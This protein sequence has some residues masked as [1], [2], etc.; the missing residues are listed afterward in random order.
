MAEPFEKLF[1]EI[2]FSFKFSAKN[3][4]RKAE[5]LKFYFYE[6]FIYKTM[7]TVTEKSIRIPI[8]VYFFP[9]A[10]FFYQIKKGVKKHNGPLEA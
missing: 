8:Y 5:N 7:R 6:Q 4:Q 10:F 3:L 1:K 2:L 9:V